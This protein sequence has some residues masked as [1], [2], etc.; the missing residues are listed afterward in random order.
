M[1]LAHGPTVSYLGHYPPTRK[2]LREGPAGRGLITLKRGELETLAC[3]T[4]APLPCTRAMYREVLLPTAPML[5]PKQPRE[6][7]TLAPILEVKRKFTLTQWGLP[8]Y[9]GMPC[10]G[11]GNCT[12]LLSRR[13]W[14]PGGCHKLIP[15]KIKTI[16]QRLARRE[17][18][19]CR[20]ANPAR[21]DGHTQTSISHR[22][23]SNNYPRMHRQLPNT[24]WQC[25]RQTTSQI[26]KKLT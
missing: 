13:I 2:P 4:N 14:C 25:K 16:T 9:P 19:V 5:E 11:G 18:Q 22:N 8:H 20:S 6:A 1:D 15:C 21:S 26:D 23:A 3:I 10:T 12:P 17:S 7:A 24:P